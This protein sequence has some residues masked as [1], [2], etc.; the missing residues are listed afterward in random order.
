MK[1][2]I[3]KNKEYLFWYL[4]LEEILGLTRE[5]KIWY[6]GLK[7]YARPMVFAGLRGDGRK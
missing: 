5:S 1:S 7:R 3:E 2:F 6:Y 4:E